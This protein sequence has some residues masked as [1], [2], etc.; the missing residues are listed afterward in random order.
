ME[1]AAI[2]HVFPATSQ[3][4]ATQPPASLP[5]KSAEPAKSTPADTG[6]SATKQ[7]IKNIQAL[8]KTLD[9]GQEQMAKLFQWLDA[10]ALAGAENW[11]DLTM[12]QAARAIGFLSKQAS[13]GKDCPRSQSQGGAS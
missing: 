13:E 10:E 1:F 4:P 3:Q 2:A 11:D 8:W 7:Q 12:E 5:A 9:Y 6:K